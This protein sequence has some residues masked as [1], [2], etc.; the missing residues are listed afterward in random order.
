MHQRFRWDSGPWCAV[1][2]AGAPRPC[3]RAG[4]CGGSVRPSSEPCAPVPGGVGPLPLG[5]QAAADQGG[6]PAA[7][8]R[9]GQG[10][11]LEG[12]RYTT[13]GRR[14]SSRRRAGAGPGPQVLVGEPRGSRPQARSRRRQAAEGPRGG[15]A[16]PSQDAERT[17][18]GLRLAGRGPRVAVPAGAGTWGKHGGRR[19]EEAPTSGGDFEQAKIFARPRSAPAGGGRRPVGKGPQGQDTKCLDAVATGAQRLGREGKGGKERSDPA[20]AGEAVAHSVSRR[21]MEWSA[22]PHGMPIRGIS[23]PMKGMQRWNSTS[24]RRRLWKRS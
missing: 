22:W 20:R 4:E 18:K 7:L 5:P 9:L 19:P 11:A 1:A 10:D 15:E 21:V 24:N 2:G 3:G 8:Q 12:R 17:G 6:P 14:G 23:T 16:T 13:G